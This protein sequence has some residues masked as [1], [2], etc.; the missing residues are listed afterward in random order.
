VSFNVRDFPET[1]TNGCDVQVV[2]TDSFLLDQLG[3]YPGLV[4]GAIQRQSNSYERPQTSLPDLLSRLAA[5][6]VPRF[7]SQV[8]GGETFDLPDI[9]RPFVWSDV[10]VRDLVD[11]MYNGFPVGEPMFW[12]NGDDGH[13]RTIGAGAMP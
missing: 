6:G 7:A 1:S 9:Q 12:A 10:Q 11:S 8:P 2:D 3:V 4:M 13:S 5:A